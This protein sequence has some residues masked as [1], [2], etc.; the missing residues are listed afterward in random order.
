M[1][2]RIGGVPVAAAPQVPAYADQ[3]MKDQQAHDSAAFGTMC[4]LT[5]ILRGYHITNWREWIGVF[6]YRFVDPESRMGPALNYAERLRGSRADILT[7]T[8]WVV[9]RSRHNRD[10]NAAVTFRLLP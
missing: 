8:G 4:A 1:S 6:V 3:L 10:P 5:P 7:D 9:Y 2:H